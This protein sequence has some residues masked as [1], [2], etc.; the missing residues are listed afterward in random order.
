MGKYFNVPANEL[1]LCRNK[2]EHRS[3]PHKGDEVMGLKH[4][5]LKFSEETLKVIS[6]N[7]KG[8]KLSEESKQKIEDALRGRKRPDLAERNKMRKG[9][10]M[11]DEV[12]KKI[13]ESLT[14]RIRGSP[15][16]ETKRKISD[17]NKGRTPWNKGMRGGK[18]ENDI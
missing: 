18:Y 3:Y 13:S 11:S 2:K 10:T 12:K 7:S 15:S 9:K 14:G 17:A 16:E 4:H 1:V 5:G 6:E 8:H